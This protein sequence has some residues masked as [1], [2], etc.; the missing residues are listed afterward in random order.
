MKTII[1]ENWGVLAHEKKAVYT[2]INITE[3]YNEIEIVIPDDFTLYE[4]KYGTK[5]IETPNGYTLKLNDILENRADE[6]VF[7]WYDDN[8]KRHILK[9]E[10]TKL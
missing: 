7:S 10:Y 1:Y 8:Y 3:A 5:I 9:L 6:P 4:T 2:D